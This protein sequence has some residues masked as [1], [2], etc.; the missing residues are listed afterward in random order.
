MPAKQQK[1]LCPGGGGEVIC[2]CLFFPEKLSAWCVL[3]GGGRVGQ[4]LVDGEAL[5]VI[6]FRKEISVVQEFIF[7]EL[8]S[9]LF[10]G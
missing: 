9:W 7:E 2:F 3:V 10:P 8:F 4:G 1:G 5:L 6:E